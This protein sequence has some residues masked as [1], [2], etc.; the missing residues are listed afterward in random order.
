MFVIDNNIFYY[1]GIIYNG[2]IK[3][4]KNLRTRIT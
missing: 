2:I 3:V 1:Y 4:F